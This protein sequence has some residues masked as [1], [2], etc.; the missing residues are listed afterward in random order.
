MIEIQTKIRKRANKVQAA[1]CLR[2]FRTGPGEYGYG[3]KF[4]GIK[5][6]VLR[7]LAKE[8]QLLS[9]PDI[10]ILLQSQYHEERLVG[11]FI[12]IL[13]FKVGDDDRQKIIYKVYLKNWRA[14]NNWDLVDTTTPNIVGEYLIKN[15]RKILYQFVKSE[16]LW[17]RRM[18]I[19]A[20]FSFIKRNQFVDT[21]RLSQQLLKDKHDLIHKA[22]GWMLREVGKRNLVAEETFLKKH[23]KTMPRT[24]LRYAIERFP[25]T[26]RKKYLI[27]NI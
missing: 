15:D 8:N 10:Q 1:Q 4:L 17:K 16:N 11:A 7:E 25:E 13:Q 12:L 22:V 21:L 2:F 5:V 27:G 6:P 19:L 26:K 3:D 23:V 24:M 9:I 20:T 14:F 18:A